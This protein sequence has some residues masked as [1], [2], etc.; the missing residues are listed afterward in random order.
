MVRGEQQ[1]QFLED[2]SS[3]GVIWGFVARFGEDRLVSV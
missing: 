1:R 2:P 3:V